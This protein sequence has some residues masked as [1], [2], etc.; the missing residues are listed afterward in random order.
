MPA[1]HLR[2][3]TDPWATAPLDPWLM[4]GVGATMW[5]W[6]LCPL[7]AAA[8]G[9]DGDATWLRF[10]LLRGSV[11]SWLRRSS[12]Y[13][14]RGN[15]SMLG[16]PLPSRSRTP[17]EWCAGRSR[18]PPRAA[19]SLWQQVGGARNRVRSLRRV[20]SMSG[21]CL[22]ADNPN[23]G[24]TLAGG[25]PG[26]VYGFLEFI[27]V[28]SFCHELAFDRQLVSWTSGRAGFGQRRKM[29]KRGQRHPSS[30]AKLFVS[31]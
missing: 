14:W 6:P 16:G 5:R 21:M 20:H 22:N 11:P 23:A 9:D 26:F 30:F 10:V 2:A 4:S 17:A 15:S 8:A 24:P 29:L 13:G 18:T 7:Q 19:A 31:F 27:L 25:G 1:L 28:E 3:A 12:P